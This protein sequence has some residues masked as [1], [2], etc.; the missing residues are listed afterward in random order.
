MKLLKKLKDLPIHQILFFLFTLTIPIQT[1]I[2]FNSDQAYIGQYF[3]YYQAFFLYFSDIL[4]IATIVSW[5]A[6]DFPANVLQKRS[7]RLILAFLALL[8]VSLF[9]VKRLALGLY[10]AFKWL[11]LWLLTLYISETFKTKRQFE[12]LFGTLFFL[13]T[14]EAILGIIQ[15][16]VQHSLGLTIIGEYIAPLGTLGLATVQHGSEKLIRAY[17]TMPHPNILAGFLL[18][19]LI[20]GFYFVSRETRTNKWLAGLMLMLLYFGIFFTFSRLVWFLA[21]VATV[22]FIVFSYYKEKKLLFIPLFALLISGSTIFAAYGSLAAGWAI[23]LPDSQSIT[24]RETFNGRGLSLIQAY[25][26]LGVG[27]GNYLEALKEK[28]PNLAAWEYQPPHNIFILLA[29]ELGILGASLFVIIL[30]EIFKPLL[31]ISNQLLSFLVFTASFL[32]LIVGLFDHYLITIQQGSLVFFSVLG[33]LAAM[34]NLKL[35]E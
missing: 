17:G 4:L 27:P 16:H 28:Y 6:F 5:L 13:G 24:L 18:I 8:L 31:N 15:F 25:P 34:A 26:L 7:F 1:R 33:M 12:L 9:H 11:E 22:G 2:I 19:S 32:L 23:E 10:A 35:P 20:C 14:A 3:S 21:L 29:A 30:F